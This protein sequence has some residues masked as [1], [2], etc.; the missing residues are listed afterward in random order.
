MMIAD[1]YYFQTQDE[2]EIHAQITAVVSTDEDNKLVYAYVVNGTSGVYY[3]YLDDKEKTEAH[4]VS[5]GEVEFRSITAY[6]DG[7]M[8]I[9][10]QTDLVAV[11]PVTFASAAIPIIIASSL[12]AAAAV[13][14]MVLI[15]PPTSSADKTTVAV[16]MVVERSQDKAITKAFPIMKLV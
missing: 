15:K 7:K 14:M 8:L 11:V 3:K 1:E 2:R 6:S 13:P 16:A 12:P 10:V 5:S 9:T 4:I